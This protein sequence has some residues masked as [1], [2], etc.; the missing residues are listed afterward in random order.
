MTGKILVLGGY[1]NF[2]KRIVKAL[3]RKNLEVIVAGRSREKAEDFARSVC[4]NASLRVSGF[5]MEVSSE[6]AAALLE[7]RPAVVINTCGPFQGADYSVAKICVEAGVHYIDLADGR[8]FVT[9]IGA[10]DERA[11]AAGVSVISGASTVPGLS[12]AVLDHF[13]SGFSR[14]KSVKIGISPGQQAER[15]LATTRGIL[16]YVGRPFKDFPG[17]HGRV[18]GWQDMYRQDYPG[19]GARWMANCEIPDLDLLPRRYGLENIRFSAGLELGVLHLGLWMLSWLIRL[20][21]P[22]PLEKLAGPMLAISNWFNRFG[23]ADGGMHMVIDGL[24]PDGVALRKSWFIIAREGDGPQIPTVPAIV[25]AAE[26]ANG[27]KMCPGAFPCVGL[28]SLED[29]LA[30]L[31]GFAITTNEE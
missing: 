18:Y 2:G 8:D 5:A 28:V 19:L 27:K 29:Y 7:I 12:S 26:I 25:L 20:G 23:S 31:R 21:I 16:S 17:S 10:L 15:G 14:Y 11:V 4:G 3:A 1:G 9:G 22:L 30:E 6:L 24:G 13:K